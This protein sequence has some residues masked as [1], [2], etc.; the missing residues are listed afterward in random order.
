[1][2]IPSVLVLTE[3]IISN[4]SLLN[5]PESKIQDIRSRINSPFSEC[6]GFCRTCGG[7]V[8]L[9]K[10][11]HHAIRPHFAHFAGEG[12]ECPFSNTTAREYDIRAQIF[13]GLQESRR[14]WLA[15]EEILFLCMQDFRFIEGSGKLDQTQKSK[16]KQTWKRPDVLAEFEGLGKIAFE[17]QFAPMTAKAIEERTNFYIENG[18]TLIWVLPVFDNKVIERAFIS[19]I[20]HLAKGNIFYIDSA[21]SDLTIEKNRL[22][23][24]VA[25]RNVDQSFSYETISIDDLNFPDYSL[26]YY[27]NA[28]GAE[29][30]DHA[31]GKR[32][33]VLN[34]YIFNE[35]YR[36]ETALASFPGWDPQNARINNRFLMAVFSIWNYAQGFEVNFLNAQPNL[37]SA[38]DSY[39]NSRDG[40]SN[41]AFIK[42]ML[43]RTQAKNHVSAAVWKKL[44]QPDA[45]TE[46]NLS[47]PFVSYVYS[48][49]PEVFRDEHRHFSKNDRI[50]PPWAMP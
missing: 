12:I 41:A 14:H 1:M 34:G 22:H 30:F 44:T 45:N 7:R 15:C 27:K 37:K 13:L 33:F 29:L 47:D 8:F 31:E 46:I 10:G 50:L 9:R 25:W 2:T 4:N 40:K 23:I 16:D 36:E 3:G 6:Q 11:L 18:I 32:D 28:S 35:E 17:V 21:A 49:F 20:S 19:D 48:M 5:F 26:P 38:L 24:G 39:L 43:E 42:F